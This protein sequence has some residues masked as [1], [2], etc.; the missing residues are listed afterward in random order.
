MSPDPLPCPPPSP[1]PSQSCVPR[2]LRVVCTQR[3]STQMHFARDFLLRCLALWH[4]FSYP[5]L[6]CWA[7]TCTHWDDGKDSAPKPRHREIHTAGWMDRERERERERERVRESEW[8]SECMGSHEACS[9]S[10]CCACC[11]TASAICWEHCA[12]VSS[13]QSGQVILP[14]LL[15][16]CVV[17]DILVHVCGTYG[18]C[19]CEANLN[20][21]D[22]KWYASARV[23]C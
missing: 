1:S 10:L 17:F 18:C 23:R 21:S 6:F 19:E 8:V 2:A 12:C 9:M 16:I 4:G 5:I 22:M 20:W 15:A 14:D 7:V 11:S 13:C 3:L